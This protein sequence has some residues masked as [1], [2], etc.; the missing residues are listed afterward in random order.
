MLI[1][2]KYVR[3]DDPDAAPLIAPMPPRFLERSFATPSLVAQIITAKYVDHLPLYRQERIFATRHG[4]ELSRQTMTEWMAVAADWLRP[5]YQQMQAQVL[6]TGIETAAGA[7][8]QIDESPVRYLAP[9]HGRTKQGDL[10]AC[11]RPGADTVLFWNTGRGADC[12]KTVVPAGFRGVIQ[13][14][15]YQAYDAFWRKRG[16]KES[17][18]ELAGCFAHMRRKFVEAL[19]NAPREAGLIIHLLQNLYRTEARLGA[20]AGVPE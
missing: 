12:L 20:A 5:V 17:G 13:C 8:V 18:I 3:R 6:K 7:Y 19:G 14:D 10:W 9:G 2:P 1:R 15:G 16:G 11:H 4:V